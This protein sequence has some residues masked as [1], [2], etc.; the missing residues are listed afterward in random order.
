MTSSSLWTHWI[1]NRG[2]TAGSGG[3]GLHGCVDV[4]HFAAWCCEI[5]QFNTCQLIVFH[6]DLG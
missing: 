5:Q 2:D 4:D 3:P 6:L 1:P